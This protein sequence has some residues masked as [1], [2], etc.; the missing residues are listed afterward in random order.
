MTDFEMWVCNNCGATVA[1]SKD[2]PASDWTS[3]T[4]VDNALKGLC[5]DYPSYRLGGVMFERVDLRD[6]EIPPEVIDIKKERMEIINDLT[7]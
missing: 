6:G 1:C 2:E 3:W 4:D 7:N 5:C